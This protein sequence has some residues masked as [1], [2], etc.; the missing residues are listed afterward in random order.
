MVVMI[1]H[2]NLL[3]GAESGLIVSDGYDNGRSNDGRLDMG[4]A[5]AVMPGQF[6]LV[7][8]IRRCNPVD[9]IFQVFNDTGFILNGCDRAC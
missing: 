1:D 7:S 3:P 9:G 2:Y 5:I 6:M 8:G 4:V